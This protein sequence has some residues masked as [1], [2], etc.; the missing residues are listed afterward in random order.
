[1]TL[2]THE[3]RHG[4]GEE[5]ELDPWDLQALGSGRISVTSWMSHFLDEWVRLI[6]KMSDT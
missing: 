4:P 3:S 6:K 2:R 1:M 5:P